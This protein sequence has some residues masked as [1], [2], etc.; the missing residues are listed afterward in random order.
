MWPLF[1]KIIARSKGL[2]A[3]LGEVI[4]A[5]PQEHGIMAGTFFEWRVKKSID[6]ATLYIEARLLAD[7]SLESTG[8]IHF[9]IDAAIR[10]R[11]NL[12]YCIEE[13]SKLE[14]QFRSPWAPRDSPKS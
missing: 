12:N 13:A 7:A 8:Y 14:P 1:A 2:N 5:T 6:G 9:D 11:D 10:L 3:Q 4:L